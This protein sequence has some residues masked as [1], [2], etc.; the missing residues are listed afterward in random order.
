MGNFWTTSEGRSIGSC[1]WKPFLE[2]TRQVPPGLAIEWVGRSLGEKTYSDHP[3]RDQQLRYGFMLLDDRRQRCLDVEPWRHTGAR[4]GEF[5]NLH[6]GDYAALHLG[7]KLQL[8]WVPTPEWSDLEW[9][10]FR[11]RVGA[12]VL[13]LDAERYR[14]VINRR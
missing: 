12:A 7:R 10:K 3:S 6:V 2:A 8:P 4:A 11:E 13:R 1:C 9:K 14:G 5:R